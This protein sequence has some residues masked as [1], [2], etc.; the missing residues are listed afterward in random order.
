MAAVDS[1]AD[2]SVVVDS[3]VDE[4]GLSLALPE[5]P[6]SPQATRESPRETPRAAVAVSRLNRLEAMVDRFTL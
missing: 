4:L 5:S 2:G 1:E 3:L 6:S